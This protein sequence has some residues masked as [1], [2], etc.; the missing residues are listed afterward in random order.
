VIA[1][2]EVKIDIELMFDIFF[3]FPV[4]G[5]YDAGASFLCGIILFLVASPDADICRR[6]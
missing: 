6:L 4:E 1:S 3:R 2:L 5:N